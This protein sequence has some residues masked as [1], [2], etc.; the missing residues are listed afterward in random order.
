MRPLERLLGVLAA[1]AVRAQILRL[2]GWEPMP[3]GGD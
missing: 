2:G 3:G 1:E